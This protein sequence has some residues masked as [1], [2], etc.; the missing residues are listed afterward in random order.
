MLTEAGP[1]VLAL[2][3]P[4]ALAEIVARR[5]ADLR[6]LARPL[7]DLGESLLAPLV[8][9]D[10]RLDLLLTAG[11]RLSL[12]DAAHAELARDALVR[13]LPAL[14]QEAGATPQLLLVA[15][16]LSRSGDPSDLGEAARFLSALQEAS[17]L[18]PARVFAVPGDQESSGPAT[19]SARAIYRLLDA[20]DAATFDETIASLF[21]CPE[22]LAFHAARLER[23]GLVV[24]A[25]A[26][27]SGPFVPARLWSSREARW[28]E[29]E[30]GVASLCSAWSCSPG[31][32]R[33]GLLGLP[34]IEAAL[35]TMPRAHLRLVLMHHAPDQL[36]PRER[37]R[38]A[39]LLDQRADLVLHGGG[40][41]TRE[42]SSGASC[43][44]TD[45]PNILLGRL[46]LGEGTLELR[47]ITFDEAQTRWRLEGTERITATRRLPIQVSEGARGSTLVP[48]EGLEAR[49]TI[50]RRCGFLRLPWL[51]RPAPLHALYVPTPLTPVDENGSP[52]GSEL[53]L[54]DLLARLRGPSPARLVVLGE[55]GAGKTTLVYALALALADDE[56]APL[57][58]V[59]PLRSWLSDEGCAGD[60]L[61]MAWRELESAGAPLPL[62]ELEER[63]RDGRAVLLVDGLDEV[64][65]A[66]SRH[67]PMDAVAVFARSFPRC[68]LLAT[69]RAAG[70]D[71]KPW[72]GLDLDVE[73]LR[74]GGF[75]DDAL[76][77]FV[78]NWYELVEPDDPSRRA[79]RRADLLAALF[80]APAARA[81]ATTPLLAT[82]IAAVHG[83]R[84]TLP[85]RRAQ[86]YEEV[87]RLMLEDWPTRT[88]RRSFPPLS[89]AQQRGLLERLAA[90]LVEGAK[91]GVGVELEREA[92]LERVRSLLRE[93]ELAGRSDREVD[94]VAQ[95]WLEHM[96][97]V[98]GLLTEPKRGR[99]AFLHRGLLEYLAARGILRRERGR[100]GDRAVAEYVGE[101]EV[102]VEAPEVW[103]LLVGSEVTDSAL[104]KEIAEKILR[105][106]PLGG[107]KALRAPLV[108]TLEFLALEPSLSGL[109]LRELLNGL[110]YDL[111]RVTPVL[112]IG[113]SP[114]PGLAKAITAAIEKNSRYQRTLLNWWRETL[115]G[116]PRPALPGLVLGT[117]LEHSL[118]GIEVRP[119]RQLV[120]LEIAEMG[121]SPGE[122]S[123]P[124]LSDTPHPGPSWR[125][126]A[127]AQVTE[128]D[129]HSR[130]T[131]KPADHL[132]FYTCGLLRERW[133][134]GQACLTPAILRR[135]LISVG[136]A[137]RRPELS[138]RGHATTAHDH[139]GFSK[140][141]DGLQLEL[142]R[143]GTCYP[144]NLPSPISQLRYQG[145]GWGAQGFSTIK[146]QLNRTL[147]LSIPSPYARQVQ[148][149]LQEAQ[150]SP[151]P[152]AQT[153][154]PHLTTLLAL[155]A[156]NLNLQTTLNSLPPEAHARGALPH[157]KGTFAAAVQNVCDEVS[158]TRLAALLLNH[159]LSDLAAAHHLTASI[160][161]P[162]Q[163]QDALAMQIAL[164]LQNRF[165]QLFFP[166]YAALSDGSPEA[167][168]LLLALGLN[169]VSTTGEWP[170]G[171]WW[172]RAFA[173][174][175]PDHW[176]PACIWHLC[177]AWGAPEDPAHE[178]AARACLERGEPPLLVEALRASWP[179]P[180]PASER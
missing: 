101:K 18:E 109:T 112:A 100:G 45:G 73:H 13:D 129:L 10:T 138:E 21:Q 71:P 155:P 98:V 120:W 35:A 38:V 119:D 6:S 49:A 64:D 102:F 95:G 15:G 32:E 130:L 29:L 53:L 97:E 17:G 154:S 143:Q 161:D 179:L 60:L 142:I 132:I 22:D 65:S 166:S 5:A 58:L 103:K 88:R 169:Q 157:E 33:P 117:E 107:P 1:V 76:E 41:E 177:W 123:M 144:L 128:Q 137:I 131:Q 135:A 8:V 34:Q 56:T 105:P 67:S 172:A 122:P 70:H 171:E 152:L 175:P 61:K 176:L 30:I 46:A 89:P 111:H 31:E 55:P 96:V 27:G 74:L 54:E 115:S 50:A 47:T 134:L 3:G 160:P 86:L 7:V 126:H 77:R 75:D 28:G 167:S 43:V 151:E 48:R 78:H 25:Q 39:A 136:E 141:P 164:R 118:P 40:V 170:W 148:A 113:Y 9:P 87:L 79:E 85:A 180:C 174:G 116:L 159:Q 125:Q 173:D 140:S 93:G 168:A 36:H 24:G 82:L 108:L 104:M 63:C 91:H 26:G 139:Q 163:R 44:G 37:E 162:D 52:I 16:D 81:L 42:R 153:L 124:D 158:L 69:G 146:L 20:G 133:K 4:P 2:A 12:K 11:M 178:A 147:R 156:H 59:A 80:R 84:A 23:W 114:I 127:R 106:Y 14:L 92:L 94:A 68:P 83:V 145:A 110:V 149:L 72:K 19:P 121:G 66:D 150:T 57:P 99:V 165:L 51:T 62:P 90:A